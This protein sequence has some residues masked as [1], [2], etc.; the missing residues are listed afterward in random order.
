MASSTLS[1]VIPG[2]RLIDRLSKALVEGSLPGEREGFGT[3]ARK[4]A[5]AFALTAL[6]VR[7]EGRN[8][9]AMDTFADSHG[10]RRMRIA[11]VNPDMPFLVDSVAAVIAAHG[12]VIDR[13]LH[14]VLAVSRDPGG[15]LTALGKGDATESLIYLETDRADAKARA[16]IRDELNRSLGDVR[17]AVADWP[18]MREAM[19]NDAETLGDDEA[20]ALLGW[21][22]D[23]HFTLLGGLRTDVVSTALG[24]AKRDADALLSEPARVAALEWFRKGGALLLVKS[25][26][27]STVHRRVPLDLVI[28]PIRQG[29]KVTGLSIYAGLWTSAALSEAP[30]AVPVLRQRL[31]ALQARLDFAP[32]SHSGKALAHAIASLPHD[33]AISISENALQSLTLAAMSIADRPRAAV[34]MVTAPLDRHL[35]AF[36]WL[37][38]DEL[39]TARRI[40]IAEMIGG[41]ANAPLLSWSIDLGDG[42]TALIRYTFD[43]RQSGRVPDAAKINAQVQAM[44]RGWPDA[45]EASLATIGD[46]GNATRLALQIGRAHV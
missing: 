2:D 13:L 38:R 11:V 31:A 9:V 5:A 30:E 35:F 42:D 27:M 21:F 36:V 4:G 33:I 25:N 22:A 7:K 19:R 12:L 18:K 45:V 1:N 43:L 3:T 28:A 8:A 16:A 41:P 34:E 24:L 44:V 14:P 15:K 37:P 6:D 40:A 20:K 46:A 17:D 29:K 39:T 10:R 32:S 26:R 23:N